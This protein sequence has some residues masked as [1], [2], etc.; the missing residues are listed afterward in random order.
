[1]L[2]IL[3]KLSLKLVCPKYPASVQYFDNLYYHVVQLQLEVV[4]LLVSVAIT[5]AVQAI[6]I[7]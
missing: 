1:M 2:Q 3:P 6:D 7:N 4:T 5:D